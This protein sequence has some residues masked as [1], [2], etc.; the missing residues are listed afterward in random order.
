ML[1]QNEIDFSAALT[2]AKIFKENRIMG[3]KRKYTFFSG[4]GMTDLVKKHIELFIEL[5]EYYNSQ[6][7]HK[8]EIKLDEN[9]WRDDI[10]P[11]IGSARN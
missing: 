4:E 5:L 1:L 10:S 2:A 8:D 7:T 11:K 3:L 9:L 6:V